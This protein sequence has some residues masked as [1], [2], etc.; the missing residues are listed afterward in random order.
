MSKTSLL[1]T[2]LAF[3]LLLGA[4]SQE[5]THQ[6]AASANAMLST[7]EFVLRTL[8]DRQLAIHTG[9]VTA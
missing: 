1:S 9:A 2:L 7:N 6:D 4:C 8:D 3:G 5:E